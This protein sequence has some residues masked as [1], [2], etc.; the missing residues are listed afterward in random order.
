MTP[1][2]DQ[3]F[4]EFD[5]WAQSYIEEHSERLFKK[6][7]NRS[8]IE[9]HYRS[10]VTRK[11]GYQSLLRCKL[12]TEGRHQVRVWD[13]DG[14]RTP[15]PEDLRDYDL[16]P[17]LQISHLWILGRDFGFSLNCFDL[18]VLNGSGADE[19]ICPFTN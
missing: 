13:Q 15:L 6:K 3:E 19:N 5:A 18:M 1:E 9:E 7:L 11:E 14:Q 10:P 16:V 2:Q 17:R 4:L 12:N 8:Q